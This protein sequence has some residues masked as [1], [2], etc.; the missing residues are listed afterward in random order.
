[1][2]STSGELPD[3]GSMD[4]SSSPGPEGAADAALAPCETWEIP[5]YAI[6]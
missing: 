6:R 5:W 3:E 4:R 2:A 1:M